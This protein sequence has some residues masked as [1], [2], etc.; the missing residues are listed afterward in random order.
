MND[1]QLYQQL[2]G[3][4][5]DWKISNIKIDFE[6][7][8]VDVF[9]EKS[10]AALL[11]CPICNEICSIYDTRDERIWRHLDTMQF[12]T[13]LHCKIPRIECK[14]HGIKTISTEWAD[15]YSRFTAMFERL[16]INILLGCQ[17]Q[18]KAKELLALSWDEIHSI[19]KRSV[20]RGLK[21]RGSINTQT[22]GV[23]EKSFLQGQSYVTVLYDLENNCVIDVEK[24]RKEES[25][26]KILDKIPEETRLA[27]KAVAADMWEPFKNALEKS[28]VNAK[29]VYDKFHV[30]KHIS[31]AVDTVRKYENKSLTK[32]GINDLKKT[33]YI[34]L[35][36]KDNMTE[37]QEKLF[38]ILYKKDLKVGK[39][40]SLKEFIKKLW[41]CPTKNLAKLCFKFWYKKV[42]ESSLEP[43]LKVADMIKEKLDNIIT[44][45][46]YKIT[47]SV[48]EGIN[49]KIQN[50][51]YT[52]RGFRN[53][54]NYKIA[55]LFFCGKL[56]LYPQN[57]Q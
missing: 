43:M 44:Y 28:L 38:N 22:L 30:Q 50:I 10:D 48:A 33:K 49:S 15:K 51:K 40:W 55:I 24:D 1:K 19:Q 35:T 26:K 41:D 56:D 7:I 9:I 23:D 25:L 4:S 2:L 5:E 14:K 37:K 52:A 54:E 36:N 8:K 3:L 6:N 11:K 17:N 39:A 12:K 13:I 34:W 27:I 42:M 53:Y 45:M 20:K 46:D 16:A 21:Q 31:K 29:I 57:S 32:E 18:T 47:N